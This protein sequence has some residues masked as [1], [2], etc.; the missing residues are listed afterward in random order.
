MF[1]PLR[2]LSLRPVRAYFSIR[3]KGDQ[4]KKASGCFCGWVHVC[5]LFFKD[6]PEFA[7]PRA[8]KSIGSSQTLAG[9]LYGIQDAGE[10]RPNLPRWL[11][12]VAFANQRLGDQTCGLRS[13]CGVE[14]PLKKFLAF[15]NCSV[16]FL[17]TSP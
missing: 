16:E 11:G 1:F 8:R 15:L 7:G 12:E 10:G 4:N 5:F 3:R 2:L 17:F 6:K 13:A 14:P 9:L